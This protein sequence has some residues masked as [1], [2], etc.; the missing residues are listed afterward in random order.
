M[1]GDEFGRALERAICGYVHQF[2]MAP[3]SA[4]GLIDIIRAALNAGP[5]ADQLF[6]A[7]SQEGAGSAGGLASDW[8]KIGFV[9]VHHDELARLGWS[10]CGRCD[11]AADALRELRAELEALR[12]DAARYRWLRTRI[13]WRTVRVN[14][15]DNSAGLAVAH[16]YRLWA[17]HDYRENPP[18][19]EHF[20]EYLD[21]AL[22]PS[23]A[24]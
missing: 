20:D 18:A 8:S 19:S 4:T 2:G 11:E 3:P 17:H 15:A 10:D 9:A 13:N 24:E 6:P 14:L 1:T 7:P 22:T 5:L 21:A 16:Q 12:K 23:G